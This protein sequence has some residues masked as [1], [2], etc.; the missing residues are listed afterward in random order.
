MSASEPLELSLVVPMYNEEDNVEQVLPELLAHAMR[1]E[2]SFEIILVNDG[3]SDATG[4]LL[5]QQAAADPRIRIIHFARNFGQTAAMAAGFAA[6]SGKVIV[7]L[8][9][10]GQNE[11]GDIGKLLARLEEGFGCVSG[12]R[13]NR[14]DNPIRVIPSQVANRLISYLSGVHLHDY[15]CSL[16]AF[17]AEYIKPA[18]LYGEM[19]RFLP[20]YAAMNGARVAEVE[21]GHHARKAGASKY[22]LSRIFRVFTDIMLVRLLQKYAT[23][24]S[25]YICKFAWWTWGLGAVLTLLA[26]LTQV[27]LGAYLA[28]LMTLLVLG[29]LWVMLGMLFVCVG[30]ACE[31]VVRAKFEAGH[32]HPWQIARTVNFKTGALTTAQSA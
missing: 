8:D 14:Q 10:D 18:R 19:H 23:R 1:L 25:H 31:L 12:W 3:S 26:V 21:V 17:R 6:A 29:L 9:G 5:D 15:G 2:R 24:P 11:A 30:I 4:E 22:G 13:K 28:A 27:I 16:K 32:T 20:I 7:P